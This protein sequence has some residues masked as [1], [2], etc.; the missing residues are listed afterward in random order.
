[1]RLPLSCRN[2]ANDITH[3]T[4][5]MGT[6]WVESGCAESWVFE[7]CPRFGDRLGI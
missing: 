5:E 4:T 1:M 3:L 6:C 7:D 2:V